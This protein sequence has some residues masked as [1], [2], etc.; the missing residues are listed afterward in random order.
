M[1]TVFSQDVQYTLLVYSQTIILGAWNATIPD[2][3]IINHI[4]LLFKRYMHLK[5]QDIFGI[6]YF[7]K[8]IER[9]EHNI[10]FNIDKLYTHYKKWDKLLP[11][12]KVGLV[13]L[14]GG[15]PQT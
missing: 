5:G 14:L 4:I 8:H 15:L 10:A 6:K 1:F 3:V 13:R 2:F 11:V 7:I 9:I 12:L